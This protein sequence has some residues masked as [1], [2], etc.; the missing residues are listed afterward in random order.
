M[1]L[2]NLD[3]DS[4]PQNTPKTPLRFKQV[5]TVPADK[6]IHYALRPIYQIGIC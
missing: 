2:K 1:A 5:I 4:G 3:P 6:D